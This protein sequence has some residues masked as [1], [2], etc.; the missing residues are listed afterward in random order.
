MQDNSFFLF[1]EVAALQAD[2]EAAKWD[3]QLRVIQGHTTFNY[4]PDYFEGIAA[5][6]RSLINQYR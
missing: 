4:G 3:N 2:M 5:N 6:I 1:A